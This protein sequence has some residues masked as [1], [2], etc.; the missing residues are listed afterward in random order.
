MGL[1]DFVARLL[2]RGKAE[3]EP[4]PAAVPRTRPPTPAPAAAPPASKEAPVPQTVTRPAPAAAAPGPASRPA[5]KPAPVSGAATR[6]VLRPVPA[7][8]AAA[9]PAPAPAPQPA[10]LAPPA[11]AG[12]ATLKPGHRREVVLDERL[13]SAAEEAAGRRSRSP[14]LAGSEARRLFA[15]TLRTGNRALRALATDAAQLARFGLPVWRDEAQL[16]GALGLGLPALRHLSIHSARERVPHYVTFAVPKRSGGERLIMAP[17]SRLKAA[18]RS[19][20]ALLVDRL[21]A[22]EFAHGFRPARSVRSNAAPHVGKRVIVHLDLKDFFPSIHFG[23]VRGLL[24]AL[25]Y[26]Y[27]VASVLATLMTEAPRQPVMVDGVRMF[28]PVGPRA[29]PQ[30]AP[31]SPGLSN[32]IVV[33]M[34]RRLAGLARRF[35]F[36]YTRYADDLTFSG[37]DIDAAHALRCLA[38]RIAQSEGFAVNHAKTRVMRA[39]ARQAVTGVVVNEVLGLSRHERRRLRASLHRLRQEG[40]ARDARLEGHLAY[41]HMLNP[42]QAQRLKEAAPSPHAE[43]R[44]VSPSSLGGEGRGEG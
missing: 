18:Q 33:R 22:S 42:A 35:G 40:I 30:G 36:A 16:A 24:I 4:P 37:D 43:E 1:S 20:N 8:P 32:A 41:L 14:R 25:G 38:T 34:D 23:R 44:Q 13:S 15:G 7:A 19:L 12:P 10:P 26:G 11:P 17:K 27:P 5:A 39:G 29:C 9:E 6:P 21:P 2:G 28:P 3:A 31:T